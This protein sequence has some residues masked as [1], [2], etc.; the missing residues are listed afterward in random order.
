[1]TTEEALLWVWDKAETLSGHL[2][3]W[4]AWTDYGAQASAYHCWGCKGEFLSRWP[5]WDE[6]TDKTFP[7]SKDC[8]YIAAKKV[9]SVILSAQSTR[10]SR[11]SRE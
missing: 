11:P 2:H 9:H 1:M 7:H 3:P 10:R 5:R 8:R 6:P 4:Q